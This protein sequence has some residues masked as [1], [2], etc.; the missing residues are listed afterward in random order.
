[1]DEMVDEKEESRKCTDYKENNILHKIK[2][3]RLKS[4]KG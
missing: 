3:E 1:V 2:K 4:E